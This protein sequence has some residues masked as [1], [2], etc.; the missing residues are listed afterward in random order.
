MSVNVIVMVGRDS[1][2]MESR[3]QNSTKERECYGMTVEISR[4]VADRAGMGPA[5]QT[6]ALTSCP[7]TDVASASAGLAEEWNN[8]PLNVSRRYLCSMRRRCRAVI[9]SAGG[10]TR[11]R[12]ELTF[13]NHHSDVFVLIPALSEWIYKSQIFWSVLQHKW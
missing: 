4:L 5:W 12:I 8:I 11:Y 3:I 6:C 2:S 13:E 1:L 10:H 9:Q 7:A